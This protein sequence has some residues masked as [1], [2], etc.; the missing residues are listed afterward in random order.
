MDKVKRANNKS[1]FFL[2]DWKIRAANGPMLF[3]KPI[4]LID[5]VHIGPSHRDP[6]Y[7][8]HSMNTLGSDITWSDE[9]LFDSKSHCLKSII[10]SVPDVPLKGYP[11]VPERTV[12]Q[13]FLVSMQGEIGKTDQRFFENSRLICIDTSTDP[14][15]L[16]LGISDN[17]GVLFSKKN[18]R[19]WILNNPL[20]HLPYG[21][22]SE[23]FSHLF[24]EYYNLVSDDTLDLL[25][26]RDSVLLSDLKSLVQRCKDV[27]NPS[28][29]Y[30]ARF[31]ED[32]ID[33]FFF[34]ETAM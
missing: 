6:A 16:C 30:F 12:S 17:L 34:N 9:W 24:A 21:P 32:Q 2:G 26:D 10:W 4:F 33:R 28:L 11:S 8:D 20:D 15:D 18:W 5:K 23:D 31:V 3:H 19:G 22:V 27:D 13:I 14:I 1:E 7:K 25:F 29:Q